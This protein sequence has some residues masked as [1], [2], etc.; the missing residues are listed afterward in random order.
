M[1]SGAGAAGFAGAGLT[2]PHWL[3]VRL[4][5]KHINEAPA[6]D[7][8]RDIVDYI[9]FG[10]LMVVYRSNGNDDSASLRRNFST[11]RRALQ[12][13]WACPL[14]SHSRDMPIRSKGAVKA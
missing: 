3:V 8:N 7:D 6:D 9:G 4:G 11:E 1:L 12:L 14:A 5:W 10:D 2:S 13:G